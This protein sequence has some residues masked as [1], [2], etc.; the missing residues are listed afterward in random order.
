MKQVLDCPNCKAKHGWWEKRMSMHHQ[1]F[2]PQGVSDY[3]DINQ[4]W[5]GKIKRCTECNRN[6]TNCVKEEA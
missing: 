3:C 4:S 1:S 2:N 6:I 5:G